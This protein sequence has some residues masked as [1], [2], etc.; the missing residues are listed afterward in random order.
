MEFQTIKNALELQKGE[1]LLIEALHEGTLYAE[2]NDIVKFRATTG[3][4][5]TNVYYLSAY[6][7]TF[8]NLKQLVYQQY[9]MERMICKELMKKIVCNKEELAKLLLIIY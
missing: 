4:F 3:K 1:M 6:N 9:M 5:E 7:L 2:I 8:D